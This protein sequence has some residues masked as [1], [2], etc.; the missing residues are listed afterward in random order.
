MEIQL[1]HNRIESLQT[2]VAVD[3]STQ[4]S[5]R[6]QFESQIRTA[7]SLGTPFSLLLLRTRNLRTLQIQFGEAVLENLLS[8]FAKRLRTCIRPD[9]P[10]GRWGDERFAVIFEGAASA[11]RAKAKAVAEHCSGTYVCMVDGKPMRP[12]LHIDVG[13][14][15]NGNADSMEKIVQR[16]EDFFRAYS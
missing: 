13:V 5:S 11:A 15:D 1:L 6:Q 2:A 16:A 4:L 10:A 9:D 14:V 3:A 8:A 7:F 12:V